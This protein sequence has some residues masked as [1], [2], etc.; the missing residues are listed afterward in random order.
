MGPEVTHY[1][2]FRDYDPSTGRYIESDLIGLGGGINT[3]A[4]VGGNTLSFSD[5]SGLQSTSGNT[6]SP[7]QNSPAIDPRTGMPIGRI[8]SDSRGN[9]MIEPVGGSTVAAGRGGVDTH[10][11]YPNG[12]NYQRLNPVGHG[13]NP[14]PHGHAHAP[15]TG[16]GR[17][18]QGSSLDA[19]GHVVPSN[20]AAAHFPLN[21]VSPFLMLLDAIVFAKETEKQEENLKKYCSDSSVSV[22]DRLSAGCAVGM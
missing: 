3:Y 15:G 11:T 10:T 20:S 5:P 13:N 8:I 16:P 4:Y 14:T 12:S 18:G 7:C 21:C 1:N 22:N 19:E 17:A 6:C 2:Y 9:N